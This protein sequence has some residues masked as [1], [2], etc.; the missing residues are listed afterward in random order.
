[1]YEIITIVWYNSILHHASQNLN[2]RYHPF[3]RI[4]VKAV[5]IASHYRSMHVTHF[6]LLANERLEFFTYRLLENGC[7]LT[8]R[9]QFRRTSISCLRRSSGYTLP[10]N[11]VIL[12]D[13]YWKINYCESKR[14]TSSRSRLSRNCTINATFP[15]SFLLR[16]NVT[17]NDCKSLSGKPKS[18][19]STTLYD[20]GRKW[21]ACIP[22]LNDC[23]L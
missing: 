2:I 18:F 9:H 14:T 10:N 8:I 7:H 19:R 16:I 20:R 6:D 1:M 5:F 23:I 3:C 15:N 13:F 12:E 4:K 11:D 22:R 17:V 21:H